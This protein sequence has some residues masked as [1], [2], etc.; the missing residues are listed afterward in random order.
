MSSPDVIAILCSDIHLSLKPPIARSVEPDWLK[1][2]DRQLKQLRQ[3]QK[4]YDCPVV[5]AGDVFDRW[6]SSPELINFALDKLPHLYAVPGQHDLPNHN[7]SELKRSAYWTLVEAGKITH[8]DGRWG[9][10]NLILYGFG[11]EQEITPVPK[12]DRKD[13]RVKLGVIHRYCWSKPSTC[14]KGAPDD[15][16]I[17][18]MLKS[19]K[20]YDATVFGDNHI[21]WCWDDEAI[22]NCGSFFRR[23]IDEIR[24]QPVVGLLWKDSSGCITQ[25]VRL[26]C[27]EDKYIDV[28]EG[29]ELLERG[30]DLTE[31]VDDLK[32][33]GNGSLDFIESLFQYL[34]KNGITK[35]VRRIITQA[36]ERDRRD[37]SRSASGTL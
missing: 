31:L 24:H 20:G 7:W 14:Y 25:P 30:L 5:C 8:L 32:S 3:L 23:K 13:K 35:S 9:D 4:K 2:M 10:E 22:I 28:E 27:A 11:W 18:K 37:G 16:Q 19:L 21:H 29:L 6:N 34:E 15:R 33:L 17:S 1:A 36:M 26:D 12:E